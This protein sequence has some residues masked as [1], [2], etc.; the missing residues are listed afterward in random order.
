MHARAKNS[1]AA[2]NPAIPLDIGARLV[3]HLGTD[4]RL[5]RFSLPET[6][7]EGSRFCGREDCLSTC[8]SDGIAIEIKK[9]RHNAEKYH[10]EFRSAEKNVEGTALKT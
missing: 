8:Q 1:P 3:S 10:A 6:F 7:F 4:R 9:Q 5:R 2:N